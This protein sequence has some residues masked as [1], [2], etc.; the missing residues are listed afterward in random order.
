MQ[1]SG[2][3]STVLNLV[4]SAPYILPREPKSFGRTIWTS[5]KLSKRL[6]NHCDTQCQGCRQAPPHAPG[7]YPALVSRWNCTCV[8]L[9]GNEGWR[10]PVLPCNLLF[11]TP[12]NSRET[13]SPPYNSV[14]AVLN[15]SATK[16]V[17]WCCAETGTLCFHQA[18]S[19]AVATCSLLS[20]D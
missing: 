17:T 10:H 9:E 8:L 5:C 13:F 18:Q 3:A 7:L 6:G 16:E 11:P 19:S 12:C 15:A 2:A 14:I 20:L 1:A 4:L